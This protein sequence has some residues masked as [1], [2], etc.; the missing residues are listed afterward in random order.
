M[1][2]EMKIVELKEEDLEKVTGGTVIT[3]D[4]FYQCEDCHH[5]WHAA[6]IQSPAYKDGVY[7]YI[8][9]DVEKTCPACGYNKCYRYIATNPTTYDDVCEMIGLTP[10]N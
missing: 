9:Y 2:E 7:P 5:S 4:I 1:S 8:E 10:I 6:T 3:A